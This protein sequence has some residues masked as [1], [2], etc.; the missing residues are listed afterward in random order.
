MG[1][2]VSLQRRALCKYIY[3]FANKVVGRRR[4]TQSLRFALCARRAGGLGVVTRVECV[5]WLWNYSVQRSTATKKKNTLTEAV[6]C[7][8]AVDE[9]TQKA[10]SHGVC[11]PTGR[12]VQMR[13]RSCT[14]SLSIIY[15]FIAL[16]TISQRTANSITIYSPHTAAIWQRSSHY[17]FHTKNYTL[18]DCRKSISAE[19]WIGSSCGAGMVAMLGVPLEN[20]LC[21]WSALLTCTHCLKS[22]SV[23]V[24]RLGVHR[25]I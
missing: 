5:V 19:C 7:R 2:C 17:V 14:L 11:A 25:F 8:G 9:R 4:S 10:S 23:C 22:Y 1:H 20:P 3:L 12:V 18:D 24:L 6:W 21:K 13:S 15:A 16:S